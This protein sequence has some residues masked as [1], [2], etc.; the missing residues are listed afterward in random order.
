MGLPRDFRNGP[1]LRI[2]ERPG[3]TK[4]R[5]GGKRGRGKRMEPHL[6]KTRPKVEQKEGGEPLVQ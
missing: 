1:V 3:K 6:G 5:G 4:L 2:W